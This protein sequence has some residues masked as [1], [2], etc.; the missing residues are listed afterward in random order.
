MSP[1]GCKPLKRVVCRRVRTNWTSRSA[2]S[3]RRPP[4]GVEPRAV[5]FHPGALIGRRAPLARRV[6][7]HAGVGAPTNC[8]AVVGV[9]RN[10]ERQPSSVH[11]RQAA[12]PRTPVAAL[13]ADA[14]LLHGSGMAL[15][16]A[17]P[18]QR[19]LLPP[20]D[21]QLR[22]PHD[23]LRQGASGLPMQSGAAC[24][25]RV[26]R[27]PPTAR[28]FRKSPRPWAWGSPLRVPPA[29]MPS[30]AP[31]HACSRSPVVGGVA[32]RLRRKSSPS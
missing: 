12:F 2:R 27:S 9:G 14:P 20:E 6:R 8:G 29:G 7:G 11:L 5:L 1:V 24:H 19:G 21:E 30:S 4:Y 23:A 16:E 31:A 3:T 32:A 13:I 26:S 15:L 22:I 18:S 10:L 17:R 25:A 28:W